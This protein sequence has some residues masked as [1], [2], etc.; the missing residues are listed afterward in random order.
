MDQKLCYTK[1]HL[2]GLLSDV[3]KNSVRLL[4]KQHRYH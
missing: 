2:I 4:Q 1:P 3:N